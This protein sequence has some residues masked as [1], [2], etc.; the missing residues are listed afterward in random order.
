M[1]LVGKNMKKESNNN[2]GVNITYFKYICIYV[3][4]ISHL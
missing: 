3:F 1:E 2:S 4:I